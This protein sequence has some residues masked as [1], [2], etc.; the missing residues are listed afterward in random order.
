[1]KNTIKQ[2]YV[3]PIVLQQTE[4]LLERNLLNSVVDK[5]TPVETAGQTIHEYN[6]SSTSEFSLEW[7]DTAMQ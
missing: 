2:R 1:M 3:H 6:G 5:V 4:I 7:R